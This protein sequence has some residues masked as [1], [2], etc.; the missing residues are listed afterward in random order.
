MLFARV[1]G[2]TELYKRGI[3]ICSCGNTDNRLKM[4]RNDYD[5]ALAGT[6]PRTLGSSTSSHK[7]TTH[8]AAWVGGARSLGTK[9]LRGRW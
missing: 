5:T 6:S 4:K 2:P 8:P 9:R 1:N 7:A 3:A